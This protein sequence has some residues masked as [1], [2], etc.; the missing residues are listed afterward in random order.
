LSSPTRDGCT[1]RR[2][3][4]HE[5]FA[6]SYKPHLPHLLAVA[7][8]ILG[9]E[10]L[11][12]D[13]LQETLLA[14][15]HQTDLPP[16]P[17]A[18]LLRAVSYRSLHLRRCCS[19]CR[20]H[21]LVAAALRPERCACNDP[22]VIAENCELCSELE[23]AVADLPPDQRRVFVL[24]EME[25]MDYGAIATLLRI[26]IGTVRS[27]LNRARARLMTKLARQARQA[28]LLPE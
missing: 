26:P 5:F 6:E 12:W 4:S 8:G 15:W 13:A 27:R 1:Q 9:S 10:D 16:N 19:R 18:W 23:E 2:S 24:R 7:G 28:T 11:A 22:S 17:R 14:L 21:E 25:Q 3:F 20:K